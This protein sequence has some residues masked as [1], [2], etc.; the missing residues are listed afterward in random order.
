M[1]APFVSVDR[2][3]KREAIREI[4]EIYWIGFVM[5]SQSA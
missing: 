4:I 5:D 2:D 3:Q 1:N